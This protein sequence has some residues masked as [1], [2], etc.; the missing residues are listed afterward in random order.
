MRRIFCLALTVLGILLARSPARAQQGAAQAETG[1]TLT[2]V[3]RRHSDFR[4]R[5]FAYGRDL[6]VYLPP[7][8]NRHSNARYPVLYLHDGQNVFDAATSPISKQEWQADETAERLIAAGTIEPLIIVGIGNAGARRMAEYTPTRDAK[9]GGGEAD[10][11]GR[12]LA[13]EVKPFIDRTYRTRRDAANTGLGGSSLGGLVTLYCGLKCPRTFGKLAV[14]SPSIWWDKRFI[15]RQVEG[16]TAKTR[17]RVWLDMGTQ[18]GGRDD[19]Q[20]SL[21][22][23]R[24]LRDALLAKGWRLDGDLKYVEA[25]GAIHSETAWAARFGDVLRFLFPRK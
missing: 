10:A 9:Y 20:S 14:V 4:S 17:Q 23:A 11:Y 2:G 12:L 25:A 5:F 1:H 13:E 7:D 18:E 21:D 15:V 16:L 24:A 6:L 19:W 3:I 22:D 8:Y